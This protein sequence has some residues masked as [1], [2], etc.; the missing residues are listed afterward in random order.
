MAG[1]LFQG[2]QISAGSGF[3][4]F[5][6]AA[7]SPLFIYGPNR[8]LEWSISGAALSG[9][10][11]CATAIESLAKGAR[12]GARTS[13]ISSFRE[14][15]MWGPPCWQKSLRR[16][17]KILPGGG[18]YSFGRS[19]SSP[20]YMYG[21]NRLLRWSIFRPDLSRSPNFTADIGSVPISVRSGARIS[22]R[23]HFRRNIYVGGP[24][25]W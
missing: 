8:L 2:E 15:S 20:M 18:C 13:Q 16:G 17:T 14:I 21:P 9:S 5:A 7:T 10:P 4:S 24:P 11:H 3:Y 1:A 23:S 25:S 19:A 6:V 12:Y 22:Q